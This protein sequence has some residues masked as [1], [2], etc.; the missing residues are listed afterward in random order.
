MFGNRVSTRNEFEGEK[1]C[2]Q[3]YEVEKNVKIFFKDFMKW[4]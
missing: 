1:K 3:F 2:E 4:K